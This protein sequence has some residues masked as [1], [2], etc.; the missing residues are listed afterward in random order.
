MSPRLPFILVITTH[1]H[2]HSFLHV[3]DTQTDESA[4]AGLRGEHLLG[5]PRSSPTSEPQQIGFYKKQ[6][7]GEPGDMIEKLRLQQ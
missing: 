4:K 3:T 2:T 7:S 1:T 6:I 5:L